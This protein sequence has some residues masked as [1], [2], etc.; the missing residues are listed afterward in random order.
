MTRKYKWYVEQQDNNKYHNKK[1]YVD[2]I[3]F[4][5]KAEA[6]RYLFLK[7]EQEAGRIKNLKLQPEFEILPTH[8][9][10]GKTVRAIKYKADFQYLRGSECVVEDVKGVETETFR[11]KKKLVEFYYPDVTIT[12]IK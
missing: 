1:V 11:L 9:K 8:K 12:L 10:N 7:S 6:R 3:R 4:D 5:S 2:G